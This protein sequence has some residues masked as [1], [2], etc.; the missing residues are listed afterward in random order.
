MKKMMKKVIAYSMLVSALQFGIGTASLEASPRNDQW[1]DQKQEQRHDQWQHKKDDQR[2]EQK[3]R[4]QQRHERQ[5]NERIYRER[6][7]NERHEWELQRR[8]WEAEEE[9]RERCH[10]ENDYH[11]QLVAQIARDVVL[12]F[13]ED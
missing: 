9:W 11:D 4:E 3:M 8:D 5:E 12:L 10:Q 2:H 1:Q 6:L 13:L 7:E